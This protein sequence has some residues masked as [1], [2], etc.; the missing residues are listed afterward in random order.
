MD[1]GLYRQILEHCFPDLTVTS[2][3][4]VGGG[5]FRVFEVNGGLIFRFPHSHDGGDLLRRERRVYNCLQPILPFPIPRYE[6][7]AEGCA[8]FHRP[9][10]GYRKLHGVALQDCALDGAALQ[11]VAAQIGEFLSILHSTPP[12]MVEAAGIPS[13]TP[14]E[15]RERQRTFYAEIRR[16]VFPVLGAEEKV[17]TEALFEPFLADEA[18]WAFELVLIHGDFDSSNI[19]CDP[20]LGRVVGILDFEEANLGD[21]AW[22]FCVLAAEYG[23]AFLHDLLGVYHQPQD[24][25]LQ[26]RIAYHARRILY[27]ELL[28]G[29]QEDAQL[30]TDHGLERLRRAMAGQEPIGGW[31]AT[32]TSETRRHEGFPD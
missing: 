1:V 30:F 10:A 13:I 15:L 12:G 23:P 18:N 2:I 25:R 7:F 9:V 32:S 24:A 5:S 26:R 28:Y 11:N 8:L 22:D 14:Q 17:W 29:I 27:H 6:Y 3:E 31:L 21:P 20:A 16:H 19:L 4:F